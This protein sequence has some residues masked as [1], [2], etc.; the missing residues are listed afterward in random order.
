MPPMNP[1]YTYMYAR[2]VESSKRAVSALIDSIDRKGAG[3][4]PCPLAP[5]GGR[6]VGGWIGGRRRLPHPHA[7]Q[8]PDGPSNHHRSAHSPTTRPLVPS[9]PQPQPPPPPPKPQPPKGSCL[10]WAQNPSVVQMAAKTLRGAG[11]TRPATVDIE[12]SCLLVTRSSGATKTVPLREG[13]AV[14]LCK[15]SE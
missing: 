6:G 10:L 15:V 8:R 11:L 5:A 2:P 7:Q 9:L 12:A 14:S 4:S 1:T 3:G 13:D